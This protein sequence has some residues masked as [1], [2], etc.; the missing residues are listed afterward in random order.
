MGASQ[1]QRLSLAVVIPAYN[2]GPELVTCLASLQ[3]Q[4]A[5]TDAEIIIVDDG[6]TQP[7]EIDPGWQFPPIRVLRLPHNLGR[8]AARNAGAASASAALLLFLDGD[9]VPDSPHWM[10]A[11]VDGLAAGAV[12]ASGPLHGGA[13]GFW[14]R[15]QREASARRRAQHAGGQEY[16]GTTANLSVRADAFAQAGGFDEAYAGYGFED[17]DLLLR[18]SSLGRIAWVD[19]PV[20]H[21][22]TLS[23]A[24]IRV[25]LTEAGGMPAKLFQARHPV[26]YSQLGYASLDSRLHP[27]LRLL[28]S[29]AGALA[30]SAAWLGDALITR[31]LMPYALG[32]HWVR[33]TTALAFLSGTARR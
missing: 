21:M 23:L 2:P 8:A 27:S 7:V 24:A 1:R 28:S 31:G 32:R 17:R 20:R 3:A 14:D 30:C 6:S 19:A 26:A 29:L 10:Q 16:A 12:A 15:Y 5:G 9:C 11:H 33:A 4:D 25:K 18:L 13:P 22:D